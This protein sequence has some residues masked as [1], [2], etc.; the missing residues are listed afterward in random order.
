MVDNKRDEMGA[1]GAGR[2]G[3]PDLMSVVRY[4]KGSD[5][6]GERAAVMDVTLEEWKFLM[7]VWEGMLVLLPKELDMLT[8][9]CVEMEPEDVGMLALALSRVETAAR[10]KMTLAGGLFVGAAIGGEYVMMSL[11]RM[12]AVRQGLELIALSDETVEVGRVTQ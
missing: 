6:D 4:S 5:G 1:A 2:D 11:Y 3:V 8:C 7:S 12:A 10:R 9:G